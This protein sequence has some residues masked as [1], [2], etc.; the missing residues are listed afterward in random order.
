MKN[1]NPYLSAVLAGTLL[2][3]S[4]PPMP[5]FILAFLAFV[6]I[7]L[8]LSEDDVKRRYL[9]LYITFFIY[10]SGTNW[11]IGSW[12]ADTDPYLT[13]SSIILAFVHP[14]FFMVPF[15]L[16]FII[17]KRISTNFALWSFPFFWTAF[18]W[19]HNLGEL[20]YPWLSI[21]NTQ[22]YNVYWVQ[23]IDITGV[24]GASFLVAMLNILL[25]KLIQLFS[26]SKNLSAIYS[27]TSGIVYTIAISVIIAI[28]IIYGIFRDKQYSHDK[29]KFENPHISVG[30]IQPAINPWRKWEISVDGMINLHFDIADSIISTGKKPQLVI[31]NETAIPRYTQVTVPHDYRYLTQ[32]VNERGISLF[33]G[34]SELQFY[35]EENK[36]VTARVDEGSDGGYYEPYNSSMLINPNDSGYPQSYRKMRLT[37]MAERLPYS[38]KIM[39]M[40]SWFEWGVGI[41]AWGIG[42]E[43]KN[44]VVKSA[45]DSII[46]GPI[47]CIE[48]IYPEFVANTAKNGA[49]FLVIIT[50]DAW[51]DY[52]PGPEQHYLIAA[53]RAIENRRYIARCANTGV[54]GV[55]SPMG[56]TISK[57]PQYQKLGLYEEIPL[58]KTVTFYSEYGDWFGLLVFLVTVILI[59]TAYTRKRLKF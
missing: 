11:W 26:Q 28:P 39:F 42:K 34:F 44:L 15:G 7:L 54:S 21:G 30:I 51:Y 31:W 3:I 52:T 53:M 2:A 18:E 32:W 37:P 59:I 33:T 4:F 25:V 57:L 5:F 29:L 40:K 10:H 47:I 36:T 48:S 23:F 12:Q 1:M 49:E 55:I 19:A 17:K 58:I 38:E 24:W 35:T 41:S 50:N 56:K 16:F 27:R 13:A 9:L 43:Q 22:I 46:L 14:F 6:P 8:T 45:S 20:S